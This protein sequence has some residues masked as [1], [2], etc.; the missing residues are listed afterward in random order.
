VRDGIK[1]SSGSFSLRRLE[2]RLW[3]GI[4]VDGLYS[5]EGVLKAR[6]SRDGLIMKSRVGCRESVKPW[7]LNG[8]AGE[9]VRLNQLKPIAVGF[10]SSHP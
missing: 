6:A 7:L 8:V 9:A 10:E 2:S 3:K 4:G 1:F 5:C